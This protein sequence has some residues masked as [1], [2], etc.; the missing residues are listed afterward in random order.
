MPDFVMIGWDGPEGAGRR[1]RLREQHVAHVHELA[2]KGR[3]VFAGPIRNDT[4]DRSIGAVII[5]G[6]DSLE[7]AR[8][9]VDRDPYVAGGVFN[10]I[11]VNPFKQVI[12]DSR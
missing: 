1:D 11:T 6:A 4:D 7:E 12:P 5:L 8:Q 9:L 10:S 3:I 2:R